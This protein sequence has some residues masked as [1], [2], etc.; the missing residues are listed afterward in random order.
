[1]ERNALNGKM[2]EALRCFR[3]GEKVNWESGISAK[4]WRELFRRC[5]YHQILPMVY[6]AVYGCPAFAAFPQQEPLPHFRSRRYR[7][8]RDR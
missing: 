2:L 5:Q 4:E 3:N 8:S 1:M 6:D 7:R